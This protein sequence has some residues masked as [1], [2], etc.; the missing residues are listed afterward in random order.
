MM[1]LK[2][3]LNKAIEELDILEEYYKSQYDTTMKYVKKEIEQYKYGLAIY[4]FLCGRIHKEEDPKCMSKSEKKFIK[5]ELIIMEED[6]NGGV[7]YKLNNQEKYIGKYE[8]DP[9]IAERNYSSLIDQ[10]EILNNSVIIMLLIRYES[11]ISNI[12][13]ELLIAFPNAYL[14]DKSITYDKLISFNSDIE[15]IKRAFIDS[16]IDEFMRKPLKEWYITFEQKHKLHFNL[17][18][19]FENFKEIYYRRNVIVHN[20]GRANSS[21]INGVSEKYICE[22]GK[23]LSPTKDYLLNA[24]D[25]TRI[26]VVETFLGLI[27][28]SADKTEI[29]DSL[30]TIGFK[31]MM[32]EKWTVSKYIYNALMTLDGQNDASMW[33][34]KVNYFV[35]CKNID[36][37]DSIRPKV[38][39]EDTSLM[40]ERLAIGKPA[41][42]NDFSEVTRI[43][44]NILGKE[45]SVN[46]VKTWPMFIQYRE[47]SEYQKL[48]ERYRELFEIET[49]SAEEIT[50]LSE[51][52]KKRNE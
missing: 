23:K 31:Y 17:N 15:E 12:Y 43:L 45:I 34:N 38:E 14:K 42:L 36:G 22:I 49:C 5:E 40:G 1:K 8:V 50:C 33:C 2:R 24:I 41:L 6:D 25:C 28:I 51:Q 30:F 46:D 39:K 16:E 19:E 9:I 10:P 7:Q 27:K 52:E 13:K 26:V 47:S 21:Y 4:K 29:I 20:Q 11:I 18:D 48:V 3:I 32:E 37:I 44:E 35:C